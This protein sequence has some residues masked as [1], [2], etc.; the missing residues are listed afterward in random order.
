MIGQTCI[1]HGQKKL[2]FFSL[3]RPF[4]FLISLLM[5]LYFYAL[6]IEKITKI[7]VHALYYPVNRFL[8]IDIRMRL[9]PSE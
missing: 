3:I 4:M 7:H 8:L 2:L 5:L 6:P 9:Q 1:V